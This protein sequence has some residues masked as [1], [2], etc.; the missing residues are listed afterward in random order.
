M[1]E[2]CKL[3]GALTRHIRVKQEE[4]GENSDETLALILLLENSAKESLLGD[5]CYPAPK[6]L[7]IGSY[8]R[9]GTHTCQ[10]S[11]N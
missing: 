6:R 1:R 11:T 8:T 5:K 3:K 2:K 10:K 7:K 9:S 4:G